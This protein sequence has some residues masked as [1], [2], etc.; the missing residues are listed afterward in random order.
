MWIGT[1]LQDSQICQSSPR[2]WSSSGSRQ[3][4]GRQQRKDCRSIGCLAERANRLQFRD[5]NSGGF[6][7]PGLRGDK[8]V[9]WSLGK[10]CS[11]KPA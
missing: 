7:K 3:T 1:K 9:S 11:R 4:A 10:R 8:R 2:N 5:G 6:L